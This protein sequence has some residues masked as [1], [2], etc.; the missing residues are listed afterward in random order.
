MNKLTHVLGLTLAVTAIGVSAHVV[1]AHAQDY[2]E[3][4][5][6]SLKDPGYK[7][8]KQVLHFSNQN[9]TSLKNSKYSYYFKNQD[10]RYLNAYLVVRDSA[11]QF[12]PV[13]PIT[14]D[15]VTHNTYLG[16]QI[17]KDWPD[18]PTPYDPNAP[19]HPVEEANH[20]SYQFTNLYSSAGIK[21][22]LDCYDDEVKNFVYKNH[23]TAVY[24]PNWTEYWKT[25]SDD[26]E[27][28]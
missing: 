21:T 3:V 7:N 28:K 14:V 11:A 25:H 2:N 26:V 13:F 20:H 5:Q 23:D 24:I 12:S 16:A 17:G 8:G 10:C 18:T 1:Q 9:L 6:N 4:V 22:A 27:V 19:L 15:K